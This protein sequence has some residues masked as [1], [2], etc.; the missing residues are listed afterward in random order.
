MSLERLL[1]MDF[2]EFLFL[3][4]TKFRDDCSIGDYEGEHLSTNKVTR[5]PHHL[6]LLDSLLLMEELIKGRL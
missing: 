3:G 4:L 1:R 6:P 2:N 5:T